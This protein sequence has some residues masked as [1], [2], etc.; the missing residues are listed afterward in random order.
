[1]CG[2]F[3]LD[4][5]AAFSERFH[6]E[7]RLEDLR[8]RYNIAPRQHVPVVIG[9][10][11]NR[12]MLMRFGLI[13]HWAKDTK[14]AFKMINAR[15]ESLTQR[16]AYCPLVATKRCLVPT[17]GFYVWR[18]D[19]RAKVPYYIYPRGSS[20]MAFAGLYNVW[21]P[22]DGH[23]VYSFTIIT[24]AAASVVAT[25]HDWMP[26]MLTPDLEDDWLDPNLRDL[27]QVLAL[28]AQTGAIAVDAY[29]VSRRVNTP[30]IDDASLTQP[31]AVE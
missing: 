4:S 22:A 24:T 10:S 1:M 28:L 23:P 5:T 29:P 20:S 19:G 2:Q 25:L 21:T 6:I 27:K 17:T 12:A 8:P 9:Q 7:N 31:N 18:A 3:T 16:A 30:S 13:R 11:P 26:V 14:T 15:V